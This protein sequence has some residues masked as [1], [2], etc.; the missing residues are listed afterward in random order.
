MV[1][2]RF[3][4]KALVRILLSIEEIVHQ[5]RI[6]DIDV[7]FIFSLPSEK[8]NQNIGMGNIIIYVRA[9]GIN[10]VTKKGTPTDFGSYGT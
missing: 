9:M 6:L 2:T 10:I 7:L 3:Y 5:I 4:M 8:I 1:N